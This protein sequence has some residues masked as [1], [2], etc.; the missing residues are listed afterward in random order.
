MGQ[1]FFRNRRRRRIREE[2]GL[3]DRDLALQLD[4]ITDLPTVVLIGL[5]A[6]P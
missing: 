6:R 5:A 4:Q 1:F 2:L 3:G